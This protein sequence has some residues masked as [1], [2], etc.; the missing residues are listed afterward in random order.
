MNVNS[1]NKR[2]NE[3]KCRG[4]RRDQRFRR[5]CRA[6]RMKPGKIEQLIQQRKRSNTSEHPTHDDRRNTTTDHRQVNVPVN[7]L[8]QQ[9]NPS[10]QM[11]TTTEMDNHQKRKRDQSSQQQSITASAMPKSTSSISLRQPDLKKMKKK[12]KLS[13]V[14]LRNVTRNIIHKNYRLVFVS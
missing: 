6:Q 9:K 5:K 2:P 4:N 1:T 11:R 13:T 10:N 12:R 7:M 14:R 3:R 8:D